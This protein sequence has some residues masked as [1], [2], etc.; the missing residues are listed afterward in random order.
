MPQSVNELK[1]ESRRPICG[2]EHQRRPLRQLPFDRV[3]REGNRLLPAK[4]VDMVVGG[5][6]WCKLWAPNQATEKPPSGQC[7]IHRRRLP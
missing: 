7:L 1:A 2:G 3:L 6:W 4:D 5:P